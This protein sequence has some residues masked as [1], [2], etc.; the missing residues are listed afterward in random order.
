MRPRPS[1]AALASGL[2]IDY[3]AAGGAILTNTPAGEELAACRRRNLLW[4]IRPV[5]PG[6][7]CGYTAHRT[8]T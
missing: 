6:K 2:K 7:G 1:T 5:D 8:G 4:S 3:L